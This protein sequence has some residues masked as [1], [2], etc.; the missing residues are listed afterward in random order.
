MK[1]LRR[2]PYLRE[3]ALLARRFADAVLEDEDTDAAFD[4]IEPAAETSPDVPP[5]KP[6]AGKGPPAHWLA[7]IAAKAP[8]LVH[9]GEIMGGA[10]TSFDL[11]TPTAPEEKVE[12]S[13]PFV[14]PKTPTKQPPQ[15]QA[16][17]AKKPAPPNHLLNVNDRLAERQTA[18]RQTPAPAANKPV[19]TLRTAEKPPA[20]RTAPTRHDAAPTNIRATTTFVPRRQSPESSTT[21]APAP[22]RKTPSVSTHPPQAKQSSRSTTNAPTIWPDMSPPIHATTQWPTIEEA[23]PA[24]ENQASTAVAYA[25][26][27]KPH[28]VARPRPQSPKAPLDPIPTRPPAESPRDKTSFVEVPRERQ[29][30]TAWPNA[31]TNLTPPDRAPL[32]NSAESTKFYE[33]ND[34]WPALE[35]GDNMTDTAPHIMTLELQ[36]SRAARLDKEQR[37]DW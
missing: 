20:A 5:E 12:T 30:S 26:P 18:Q 6:A 3:I 35:S 13:R 29:T 22:E 36:A 25:R 7:D 21:P 4:P 15:T 11:R 31:T 14:A 2:V 16:T 34:P 37:G 28:D 27:E 1:I 23:S 8:H 19:A 10:L 33:T 32:P 24:E 17:G 9:D